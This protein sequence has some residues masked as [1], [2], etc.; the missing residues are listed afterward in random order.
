MSI[1]ENVGGKDPKVFA[2][3]MNVLRVQFLHFGH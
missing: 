3:T 1:E 2:P